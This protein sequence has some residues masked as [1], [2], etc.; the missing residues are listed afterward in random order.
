MKRG[1]S[2]DA[3]DAWVLV[4]IVI[5]LALAIT[6]WFASDKM[7]VQAAENCQQYADKAV[8]AIESS[9]RGAVSWQQT[10]AFRAM[11]WSMLYQGCRSAR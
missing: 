3:L 11:S 4:V 9:Y 7:A 1:H 2:L 5:M 6:G 10:D 8:Q